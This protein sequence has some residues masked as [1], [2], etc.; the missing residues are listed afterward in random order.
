[1][2]TVDAASLREFAGALD[3]VSRDLRRE[4]EEGLKD[5]AE[6]VA[7]EARRRAPTGPTGDLKDSIKVAG[8]IGR[9]RVEVTATRR[10][11]QYPQ[12]YRYPRRVHFDASRKRTEFLYP[13]AEAKADEVAAAVDRVVMSMID[14]Y[15]RTAQ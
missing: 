11:K 10:S 14:K 15:W 8:R 2:G 9:I 1:M 4:L 6:I 5:G 13:A 3:L 7:R 12:G